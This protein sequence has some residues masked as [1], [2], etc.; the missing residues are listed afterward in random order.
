MATG[1]SGR[2]CSITVRRAVHP[3]GR[4]PGGR[5]CCQVYLSL[6]GDCIIHRNVNPEGISTKRFLSPVCWN[7]VPSVIRTGSLR[8]RTRR[9]PLRRP[10][11]PA[12]PWSKT[13]GWPQHTSEASSVKQGNCHAA[14]RKT[15]HIDGR[16]LRTSYSYDAASRLTGQ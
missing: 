11:V 10:T 14:S 4:P 8:V 16:G 9:S 6:I 2:D 3:G 15:L 13:A 12:I 1:R 7:V 5:T